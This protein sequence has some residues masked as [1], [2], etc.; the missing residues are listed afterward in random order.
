MASSMNYRDWTISVSEAKPREFDFKIA[1]EIISID[2]ITIE[3]IEIVVGSFA[4]PIAGV[5][6]CQT[7]IDFC[8]SN[9]KRTIV[10]TA[11]KYLA[12]RNLMPILWNDMEKR[13]MPLN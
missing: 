5:N 6:C 4:D 9:Q 11:N 2:N 1:I 10:E 13:D 3:S 7:L 12:A 8:I